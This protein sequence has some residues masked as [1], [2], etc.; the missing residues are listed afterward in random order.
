MTVIKQLICATVL[1]SSLASQTLPTNADLARDLLSKEPKAI[2]AAARSLRQQPVKQLTPRLQ[3]ALAY[4]HDQPGN[5]AAIVRLCLLDALLASD[6]RMPSKHLVPLLEDR[7]AATAA[8]MLLERD[9]TSNQDEL[10]RRFEQLP[11]SS[12]STR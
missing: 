2:T 3:E 10:L 1:A 6:V 8:L 11:T 4:W 5:R 12:N 7:W 9:H